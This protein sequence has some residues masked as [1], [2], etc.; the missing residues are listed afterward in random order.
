MLAPQ[1]EHE[2]RDLELR[3]LLLKDEGSKCIYLLSPAPLSRRYFVVTG[4]LHT[5]FTLAEHLICDS[6][7]EAKNVALSDPL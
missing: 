6:I 1:R 7:A 4:Q 3:E 5:T 2:E